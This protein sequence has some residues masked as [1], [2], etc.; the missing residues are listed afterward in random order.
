MTAA[1]SVL[2]AG[3]GLLMLPASTR[4]P[5]GTG[6]IDCLFTAVSAL[7]V[8]GLAVVDT[9]THWTTL[10]HV[11][12]LALIQIGGTGVMT[13]ATLLGLLTVRRLGMRA[14]VSATGET[15]AVLGEAGRV[16]RGIVL[17]SLSVEAVIAAMVF[18]GL[19]L[20]GESG[21]GQDLWNAV[22]LAVS[23]FNN[24]GFALYSEGLVPFHSDPL[25]CLPI[26]AAVLIGGLGFPVIAELLKRG[27]GPHSWSLTTRL[28]LAGTPVLVLGGALLTLLL[29]AGNPGTFG[30]LSWPVKLMNA[31]IHAIFSR[32]AGF[33][34]VDV[35]AMHE[36]TWLGTELVMLIGGGPA[37]TAGGL[38][39][40][41]A[42][43]LLLIIRSELRGDPFV[44]AFGRRLPT[45]V[46]RQVVTVVGLFALLVASA[47]ML[48]MTIENMDLDRVL[49]EVIS[50]ATT[51]GLS[52][53]ITADLSSASKLILSVLMF[54]GRVGPISLG[55]ALALRPRPLL[56]E[57]PTERP[58]IG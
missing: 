10:G 51:T 53:G 13:L 18:A 12:I 4:G 48:I 2:A 19:R 43:V 22:F 14:R 46:N 39:V 55:T 23:G 24:A 36:Q 17:T 45:G 40:T 35:G 58:I 38:K 41:T 26:A 29:E 21:L 3:T 34:A 56:Y 33:N 54:T 27:H 47:T 16:V 57:P 44:T 5:G 7:S 25:V 20:R 42:L 9:E 30:P 37:G 32:T 11:V 31:L 50:A 15:H 6:F 28:V 52:T 49:F 1:A 8:T